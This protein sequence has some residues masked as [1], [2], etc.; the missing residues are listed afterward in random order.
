[1]KTLEEYWQYALAISSAILLWLVRLE[2]LAIIGKAIYA[3]LRRILT[4]FGRRNGMNILDKTIGSIGGVGI[5][6]VKLSISKGVVAVGIAAN[7]PEV[8]VAAAT[9]TENKIDDVPAAIAAMALKAVTK[10]VDVKIGTIHGVTISDLKA[11]L[12]A[13]ALS[14]EFSTDIPAIDHELAAETKNKIDDVI[15]EVLSQILTALT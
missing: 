1:M 11:G 8:I 14:V 15:A 7:L 2:R 9:K 6:N 12:K 4:L 10:E 3:V 13:G 5:A